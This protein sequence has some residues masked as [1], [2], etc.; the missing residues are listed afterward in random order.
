MSDEATERPFGL[1][2]DPLG[3]GE[4]A[5]GTR[6]WRYLLQLV[7]VTFLVSAAAFGSVGS[8]KPLKRTLDPV[9]V[10]GRSVPT[11]GGQGL[12]HLGLFA[13]EGDY[14]APIPFQ[15][16]QRRNGDYLYAHGQI[17]S[18]EA[19]HGALNAEDEIA[20]ICSDAGPRLSPFE[21][22]EG[23]QAGVEI[24]VSDPVDSGAGYVYLLAFAGDA[25]RS[26]VRYV[27]Y[28]DR[29]DYIET[30]D[31]ALGYLPEAPISIGRQMVRKPSGEYTQEITD[32][33]KIRIEGD[34]FW[35]LAHL[36]RNEN[37]FHSQ[38]L[39]YI[40]GPVR[41]IRHTK[42][43]QILFWNIP[44]PSVHLTSI[45]WKTG[46]FFPMKVNLPFDVTSFFRRVQ[47]NIYV[48]SNPH[49]LGRRFYNDRNPNG[50]DID[51]HMSQA[52][53]DL[54]RGPFKWNIVAGTTA[55]NPEGWFSRHIYDPSQVPVDISL[56]YVDD[57]SR[58]DPPE[59]YPGCF[60]CLGYEFR[61]LDRLRTGS[62]TVAIQMFPM[63][64]YHRGD[65]QT[66]LNVYDHPLQTH[67][68]TIPNN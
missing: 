68:Q 1:F 22:P 7:A 9:V 58:P 53:I 65:E 31:Y 28:H 41:V 20:F 63:L 16:D 42:N 3:R 15:I 34:L 33:Q 25:P 60:G 44:T 57:M 14:L 2:Y 61:G 8:P 26:D 17:A 13:V 30:T 62:F 37:D 56:H 67:V 43:W 64:S 47:M 54:D 36:S 50:V 51:G 19:G 48:D 66:F 52:E 29:E 49:V 32:R 55:Q 5:R 38:V 23:A 18:P 11:L 10:L 46:M 12:T 45:Y 40:V 59:R 21:L 39:G 24:Q 27:T 6:W 35:N 4:Q